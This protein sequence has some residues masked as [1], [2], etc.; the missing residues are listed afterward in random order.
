VLTNKLGSS[1][2]LICDHLDLTPLLGAVCGAKDTPWLKPE[3][4]FTA[5]AL[6]P[7][8]RRAAGCAARRRFSLRR[9]GRP[10][11]GLAGWAVTTGTHGAE[12]LRAA[13]ADRVFPDLVA[14]R[15]AL[16]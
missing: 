3:P 14:L 6:R 15:A 2:R 12:E 5:H 9:A 10:R 4:A 8:R 11:G 7:A 16:D 13:G 1:S